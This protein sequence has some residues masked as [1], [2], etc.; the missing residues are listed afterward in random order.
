MLPRRLSDGLAGAKRANAAPR[1]RRAIASLAARRE[2]AGRLCTHVRCARQPGQEAALPGSRR[3]HHRW[4]G[5][6]DWQARAWRQDRALT[7]QPPAAMWA[8]A[9]RWRRAAL[10][11]DLCGLQREALGQFH[12]RLE[13][14]QGHGEARRVDC[15]QLEKFVFGVCEDRSS[16]GWPD[17]SLGSSRRKRTE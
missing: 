13:L 6:G 12:A 7:A 5:L 2:R 8:A 16:L 15:S 17:C 9:R 10:G 4:R 3:R 11:V 1:A 14:I